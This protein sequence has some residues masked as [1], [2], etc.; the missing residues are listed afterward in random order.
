MTDSRL[1]SAL[2]PAHVGVLVGVSAG[3]YALSLA[4]MTGLQAGNEA[5]LRAQRDPL[6]AAIGRLTAQ[7]DQL[8]AR[9][10]QARAAYEAAAAA[11]AAT[12]TGFQNVAAR[13]AELTAAVSQVGATAASLP[14]R[15]HIP[16]VQF[17]PTT[18]GAVAY[19][20]PTVA[21]R[22]ATGKTAPTPA[23]VAAAAAPAPAPVVAYVPPPAPVIAPAPPPT[24]GG[25]TT[26]ST[27]P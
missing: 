2:L 20:A 1:R 19:R 9:V 25:T 21:A 27:K 18:G 7:H 12:G 6:A 24:T 17:A 10:D 3:A 5:A 11:Y 8:T 4:A 26:A 23:P 16:V 13:L 22:P 14:T 15:V